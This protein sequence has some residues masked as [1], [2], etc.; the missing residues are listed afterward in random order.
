MIEAVLIVSYARKENTLRLIDESIKAGMRSI[1][2]SIDG[3]PDT[4]I[5]KIQSELTFEIANIATCFTG[6]IKIWQRK[7]NMGSGASV[8]ASLDWVFTQET[9]V[10]ILE[11][12]LVISQ[13][14][15]TFMNIGILEMQ[16]NKNLKIVTGTNPFSELTKEMPGKV[17]YPVSWGWAT[18]RGNWSQLRHLIFHVHPSNPTFY[19]LKRNQFWKVGKKRALLGR[20]EAWDVPL[21]SEMCKTNFFTLIPPSNLI[22][23]IGFD[24]FAVHTSQSIWPLNLPTSPLPKLNEFVFLDDQLVNLNKEF[25]SKVFKIRV[26]HH[27]VWIAHLVMDRFRF[28]NPPGSLLERS[29]SEKFPHS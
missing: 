28:G 29:Q 1:Y 9:A 24:Q 13:D 18:T 17:N 10:C 15:F 6:E 16:S 21:A 11:D 8:I 14:F 25:E 27:F 3:P 20:I 12:D 19:D 5:Q 7:V 23:N 4:S 22:K 26:R 2:V